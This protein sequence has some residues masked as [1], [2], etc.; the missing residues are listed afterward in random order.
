[1]K[2]RSFWFLYL[3]LALLFAFSPVASLA[4]D[5]G[6]VPP[7]PHVFWGRLLVGAAEAPAGS[8]VGADGEGVMTPVE[9]NPIT[10]TEE[11]KYG[12]PEPLDPKLAVNGYIEEGTPLSFYVD[13]VRAEVREPPGG[14]WQDTYPFHSYWRTE[15][16]VR[17]PV[18]TLTV[19][20]T[21]CCTI[22][23]E[24]IPSVA[25]NGPV[26]D[27]VAPGDSKAFPDIPR[28]TEVQLTAETVVCCALEGWEVDGSP[29]EGNPIV[30]TMDDNYTAVATC[31]MGPFTLEVNVDPEGMGH[32]DVS[33]PGEVYTCCTTITLTA[34]SDDACWEFEG[35]SG[36]VVTTTNPMSIHMDSDKVIT[37]TFALKTF[38]LEVA[39]SPEGGGDVQVDGEV[40]A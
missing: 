37:A 36:A 14:A 32:V 19:A 17:V 35:W 9:G 39:V 24:Y 5:E 22:S 8:E 13:E 30:V 21:G 29:V 15:L 33:P 18:Y 40:A 25:A 4:A 12:G 11:G 16:D 7:V 27:T 6:E 23:V 28:D 38:T 26:T 34:V 20:S 3:I 31:Y 10:T 2:S 1:M